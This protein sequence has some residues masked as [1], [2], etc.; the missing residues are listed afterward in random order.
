MAPNDRR[1]AEGTRDDHQRDAW[2]DIARGTCIV[3]VVLSHLVS[4]QYAETMW[5]LPRPIELAWKGASDLFLPV[6]M[7]LFFA[8]SG[9][10]ASRYL[11]RP[12]REALI[13][14]LVN[15]YYL[16]VVWLTIHTIF[17]I[18][19]PDLNTSTAS[20]L[21]QYMLALV[22]GFTSLWFLYA[23]PVYYLACRILRDYP[24]TV[25]AAAVVVAL[26][27]S[28]NGFPS[29]GNSD[30]L[31]AN[32]V[33]FATGCLMPSTFFRTR[34]W[35]RQRYASAT[36]I[37]IAIAGALS[38]L[39]L[40]D[41]SPSGVLSLVAGAAYL[42]AGFLGVTLGAALSRA[43]EQIRALRKLPETMTKI[44]R[45]TLPIYVLHLPL[46]GVFHAVTREASGV[47]VMLLAIYPLPATLALV[48][49]C[50]LVHHIAL[51]ARL[52]FLFTPPWSAHSGAQTQ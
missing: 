10:Y 22:F 6:R 47:P 35:N 18:T 41:V 43:V 37:Y 26:G 48:G 11:R 19:G 17:W 50:L 23:L 8:I 31:F 16:Y 51:L 40:I 28:F 7:P 45:N 44:G 14:R 32:F 42:A 33:F 3:M 2:S 46:L 5:G 24:T 9:Y 34:G 49:M 39:K 36:A 15:P 12:A 1:A 38:L 4:K 30:S 29:I 52:A 13:R 25:L 27:T 21:S 20:N